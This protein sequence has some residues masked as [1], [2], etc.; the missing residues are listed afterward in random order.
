MDF[1]EPLNIEA[2][3]PTTKEKLLTIL[4]DEKCKE[5]IKG[6]EG[7]LEWVMKKL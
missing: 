7:M 5:L 1:L 6:T 4:N 2:R 3:Y